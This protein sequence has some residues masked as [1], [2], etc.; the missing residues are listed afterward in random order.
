MISSQQII[1][2]NYSSPGQGNELAFMW[3]H[4]ITRLAGITF[5][6]PVPLTYWPWAFSSEPKGAVLPK[7]M[8]VLAYLTEQ[9][10]Y[11]MEKGL[12]ISSSSAHTQHF[13]EEI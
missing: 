8:Q 9:A 1:M 4:S 11:L 12:S 6:C 5:H 2:C 13:K 10:G 7:G 3:F